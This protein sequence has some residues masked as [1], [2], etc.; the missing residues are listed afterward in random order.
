MLSLS[1]IFLTARRCS[2]IFLLT[3]VLA[4]ASE[5]A[6]Q[7]FSIML[8]QPEYMLQN[9]VLD[10]DAMATYTEQVQAAIK[11]TVENGG[12]YPS[13]G[14]IA[15]AVKPSGKTHAWLDLD[16]PLPDAVAHA[17]TAAIKQVPPFKTKDGIVVYALKVGFWDAKASK[18]RGPAPAEW[19]AVA[20]TLT[21]KLEVG[22]LVEKVWPD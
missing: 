6:F 9:R 20:A 10:I 12:K 3:P 22:Q 11:Q 2:L 14:F 15:L 16:P 13:A 4:L 8:M 7:T 5:Q 1:R 17:I 19:K 18:A 21:E